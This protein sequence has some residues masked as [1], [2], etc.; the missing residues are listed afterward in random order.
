MRAKAIPGEDPATLKTPY[1]LAPDLVR[2]AGDET[3]ENGVM[4]DFP[5]QQFIEV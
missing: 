5:T 2:L 4:W 1:D 3:V